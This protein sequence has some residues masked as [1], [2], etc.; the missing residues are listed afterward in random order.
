[1]WKIHD[2]SYYSRKEIDARYNNMIQRINEF[3]N[4]NF[5][6]VIYNRPFNKFLILSRDYSG[7]HIDRFSK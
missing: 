7:F 6:N 1:M 2:R 5:V 4:S 3:D